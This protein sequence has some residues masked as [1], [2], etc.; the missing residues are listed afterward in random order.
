MTT[1]FW[2]T[3]PEVYEARVYGGN[4]A[5]LA[6]TA[7]RMARECALWHGTSQSLTWRVDEDAIVFSFPGSATSVGWEPAPADREGD[8]P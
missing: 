4:V 2:V 5:E 8:Q 1:S 3:T 7:R 6:E